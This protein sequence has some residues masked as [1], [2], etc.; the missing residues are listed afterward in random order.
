MTWLW[1]Q[2]MMMQ[3]WL[4]ISGTKMKT[5]NETFWI[6]QSADK[7]YILNDHALTPRVD[8]AQRFRTREDA[9]KNK[10]KYNPGSSEKILHVEVIPESYQII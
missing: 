8:R 4:N 6:I 9:R 1:L 5:K 7:L 2:K 3:L 10:K